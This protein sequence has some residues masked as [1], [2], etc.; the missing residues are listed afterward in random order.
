LKQIYLEN[1]AEIKATS[2]CPDWKSFNSELSKIRA[3]RHALTVSELRDDSVGIASP[4][5]RDDQVL[6]CVALVFDAE[7]GDTDKR[8]QRLISR[9]SACAGVISDSLSNT[10]AGAAAT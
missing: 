1:E 4:I 2:R 8:Y 6:G 7:S 3:N 9:V 10:R 5:L